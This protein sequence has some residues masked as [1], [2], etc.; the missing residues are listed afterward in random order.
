[1]IPGW[2]WVEDDRRNEHGLLDAAP[3]K[4][5]LPTPQNHGRAITMS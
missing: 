4:S 1:M 5:T 3:V 2:L